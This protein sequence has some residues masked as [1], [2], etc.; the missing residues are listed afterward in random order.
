MRRSKSPE[1]VSQDPID[2]S[3]LIEK[4]ESGNKPHEKTISVPTHLYDLLDREFKCPIC[5]CIF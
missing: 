1:V 5:K 2:I 3:D 4:E